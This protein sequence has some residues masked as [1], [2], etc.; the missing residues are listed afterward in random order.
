[1]HI[2]VHKVC[3]LKDTELRTVLLPATCTLESDRGT[4]C[5][6]TDRRQGCDLD[7]C[8]GD[9][10]TT[11]TQLQEV[12][13]LKKLLWIMHYSINESRGRQER[14]ASVVKNAHATQHRGK[15]GAPA[16]A[17]GFQPSSTARAA[18]AVTKCPH[19]LTSFASSTA[20]T[21]ERGRAPV[22]A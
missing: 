3:V 10:H 13:P 6:W 16:S 5:T 15:H 18:T 19:S 14:R 7:P 9:H 21:S 17:A 20:R 2:L 8:Y 1:V 11:I 22:P 12:E 4:I